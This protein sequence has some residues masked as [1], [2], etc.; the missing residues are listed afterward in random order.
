VVTSPPLRIEIAP[1]GYYTDR[2]I[3]PVRDHDAD[4]FYIIRARDDGQ[5]LAAPFRNEVVRQ[6]RKWKPTLDIRVV[7][8]DLWTMESAVETFS[9]IISR[10][11]RAGNAVW[12]NLST[13]SKLEAVAAAIACMAHGGTPYYVR[14]KSYDRPSLQRPLASGVEAVDVVPAFGLASPSSGG[15]AILELLAQND[16]GLSKKALISGLLELSLIPRDTLEKSLQARYARLQGILD[17]LREFP[18]LVTIEGRRRAGRVRITE[19]G[20]LALRIFSPREGLID[21]G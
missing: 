2:V 14:M 3:Q 9:A 7:G 20:R 12:V 1:L 18:A 13:G 21:S 5:D 4:R 10:E 15:L 8:T 6:L 16:G 17:R 11:V 19:R